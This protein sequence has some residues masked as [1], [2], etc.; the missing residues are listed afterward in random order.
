ME[1]KIAVGGMHCKSCAYRVKEA[2]SG[3]NG[4]SNV[5]VDHQ[6]GIVKVQMKD[7]ATLLDVKKAIEGEGYKVL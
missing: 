2:V 5:E 7:S 1:T 6:K 3:I 4:V